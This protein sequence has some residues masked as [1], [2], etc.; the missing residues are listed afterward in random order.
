MTEEKDR[1]NF[2]VNAARTDREANPTHASQLDGT[3]LQSLRGLPGLCVRM[4]FFVVKLG[5]RSNSV[6]LKAS[7][8]LFSQAQFPLSSGLL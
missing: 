1:L 8:L 4:D 6:T 2:A 7:E 5:K 3:L